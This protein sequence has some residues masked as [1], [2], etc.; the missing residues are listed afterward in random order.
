MKYK[1]KMPSS[2]DTK[3][4]PIRGD[5]QYLKQLQ[6]QF[7]EYKTEIVTEMLTMYNERYLLIFK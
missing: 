2:V 1:I 7:R 5:Y 3:R 6:K 4:L